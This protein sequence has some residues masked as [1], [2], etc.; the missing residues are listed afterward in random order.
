MNDEPDVFLVDSHSKGNGG[1]QNLDL[2]SLPL[3]VSIVFLSI[4]LF[5]MVEVTTYFFLLEILNKLFAACSC[6]TVD[7]SGV[8]FISVNNTLQFGD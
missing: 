1:D 6:S 4:S 8:T 2:I 7:N 3:V 5:G